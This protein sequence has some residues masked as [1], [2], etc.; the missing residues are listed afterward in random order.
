MSEK[1]A[2]S[3]RDAAGFCAY[4]VGVRILL[5]GG[6]DIFNLLAGY[7]YLNQQL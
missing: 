6:T 5:K 3:R 2:Q 4:T 7:I 1:G